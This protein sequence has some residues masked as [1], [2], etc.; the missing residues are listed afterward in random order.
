MQHVLEAGALEIGRSEQCQ[1]CLPMTLSQV[2]RHH[3]SITLEGDGFRLT[4]HS[5]NGTTV[6]GRP[7]RTV[8]LRSGDVLQLGSDGP[9]LRIHIEAAPR[10]L[11]ASRAGGPADLIDAGAQLPPAVRASLADRGLY[12]PTRDKGR[13][14]GLLGVFVVLGM[15][16]AGVFMGLLVGL[17][18]FFELGL[19]AALV[20]V[21]V[22]FAAAPF[23]LMVWLWLDR[24]DPE[25]A[26]ILTGALLWGAGA[27]TFVSGMLNSFFAA[28]ILAATQD[29]NAAQLLSA[30]ISAPIA[31]EAFKGV[32]VLLVFLALRREFDGVLDGIMYAG[33]VALGFA[34]VENVLYY[35]R[36]VAKEGAPGLL[37]LFFFR[38]VLGPFS[39]AVFTSMTGIGCGIARETHNVF[40]RLV[41]PFVG[42][43][44]AVFLHFLWNTLAAVSGSPAGF[45]ILYLLIWAPLFVAFFAIVIWMGSREGRL[46]R[47]M[48]QVEVV[49]GL[50]TR[51]QA[52]TVASWPRRVGWLLAALGDVGRFR[53]RR[54]FLH[55]ATRLA[56]SYWHVSRATAAGGQTLS[57]SQIPLFQREIEAL[58]ASV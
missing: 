8:I 44:G 48:L 26:W 37:A 5:V 32:A 18:S 20:G 31:E 16:G 3:A 40:L 21:S 7:V 45:L 14:S 49:R 39:H 4:D 33:I 38:G 27:A 30:S 13:R 36:V 52:D 35:G 2:S 6:N 1:V 17:L 43:G 24:Y 51:E 10:P 11:Q 47:R 12:D 25:P 46:I 29:R 58:R 57:F 56:L 55:A 50:V 54:A 53:A 15:A 22:A 19:G 23:Y 9:R 41:M 28:V 42:Y 34:T